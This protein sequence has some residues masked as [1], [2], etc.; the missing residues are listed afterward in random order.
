MA[1]IGSTLRAGDLGAIVEQHGRLYR[2]EYQLDERFEAYVAAEIAAAVRGRAKAG[3]GAVGRGEGGGAD[4]PAHFWVV[5]ER[6]QFMGSAAVCS[7]GDGLG[8]FRWFLLDPAI[9]SQ[10]IGR[11]LLD[12]ALEHSRA[13][14]YR[15]LF[16]WTFDALVTA[17]RLYQSAG[18]VETQRL[19]EAAPWGVPVTEVR[20]DLAAPFPVRTAMASGVKPRSRSQYFRQF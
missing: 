19:P 13:V 1:S 15:A 12:L 14:G 5:R 11:Q 17:A 16:L 9:R 2:A 4:P 7:A 6:N 18:F 3:V 8:Q 10:G 20:Y